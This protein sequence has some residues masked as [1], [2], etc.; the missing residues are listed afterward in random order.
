MKCL[1]CQTT[2]KPESKFCMA[3]GAPLTPPTPPEEAPQAIHLYSPE[4]D[5]P[6]V[7]PPAPP[8]S[9]VHQEP[10]ARPTEGE[11][12]SF[13]ATAPQQNPPQ[14]SAP[15]AAPPPPP[16][17]FPA[18]PQPYQQAPQGYAYAPAKPAA[19][20]KNKT[21]W[22]VLGAVAALLII[23]VVLFL[24]VLRPLINKALHGGINT[25]ATLEASGLTV[26]TDSELPVLE[27]TPTAEPATLDEPAIGLTGSGEVITAANASDIKQ[28]TRFGNGMANDISVSP[29]SNYLAVAGSIGLDII[30]INSGQRVQHTFDDTYINDVLFVPDGM[31]LASTGDGVY[32]FSAGSF[33][34]TGAIVRDGNVYA[35]SMT[36]DGNM[37]A[38]DKGWKVDLY[39][40]DGNS[41]R[42]SHSMLESES[43][44]TIALSLDGQ[45]L[46]SGDYDGKL[47]I[48]KVDD[49][50]LVYDM[51]AHTEFVNSIAWSKDGTLLAA[52]SDD[53]LI[54]LW[55]AQ[56]GEEIRHMESE[57]KVGCLS[58]TFSAND[59]LV[60]ATCEAGKIVSWNTQTGNE[61][62]SFSADSS[63]ILSIVESPD[64][65][66]VAALDDW[67]RIFVWGSQSAELI[68]VIDIYND[69][70][71]SLAVSNDGSK[72]FFLDGDYESYMID[73]TGNPIWTSRDVDDDQILAPVFSQDGQT[74]IGGTYGG[75]VNFRNASDGAEKNFFSAH[76]DWIRQV[77]LSPDGTKL[78]TASDDNTLKVWN[79]ESFELLF[80]LEG[81]TDYVRA[82]AFSPDG[83]IIASAGDDTSVRLWDAQTGALVRVLEGHD[84]WVRAVA[85]SPDGRYLA[86][87]GD[88]SRVNIWDPATGDLVREVEAGSGFKN[89]IVF[90]LDSEHFW[91]S[92]GT[93][94]ELFAVDT[95]EVIVS[96]DQHKANILFFALS[97]DGSTLVSTSLDGTVRVWGL[98]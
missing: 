24:T 27:N 15:Q 2:N 61:E 87:A 66:K 91:V 36:S 98:K 95:P 11:Y 31:L 37:F 14:Q 73:N 12:I 47:K 57:E 28:L 78:V 1:N 60:F 34:L 64:G 45:Y 92:N 89:S 62:M 96:L 54:S 35:L 53:S 77:A 48:W 6:V 67:G 5:A 7:V 25:A 42:Y 46:A 63:A 18:Q 94:L 26:E 75:Y 32:L 52:A 29:D 38:A 68:H 49:S 41:F 86:S 97:A 70:F 17:P 85:F 9:P 44:S 51:D 56:T 55:N 79:G 33:E 88:G 50:S 81:H 23:C 8:V 21:L 69:F 90:T 71:F 22:I 19:P 30:N 59:P 83:K 58:L 72:I 40:K 84:D 20:K 82:A 43:F 39:T 13:S 4:Q 76:N 3:C 10:V 65:S 93:S 16:P 74:L 80:T